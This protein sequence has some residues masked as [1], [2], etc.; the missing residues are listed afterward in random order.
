MATRLTINEAYFLRPL[1]ET[2]D[3]EALFAEVQRSRPYLREWLGWLDGVRD[4]EDSKKF[5]RLS[6]TRGDNRPGM[7]WGIFG[8]RGLLG[9]VDLHHLDAVNRH[10]AIGYWLAYRY[11]GQG[12]MTAAVRRVVR[13][14]FEAMS[15]NRLEIRVNPDNVRSAAIPKRLGFTLEGRLREVEWLYTRFVDHDVYGLLKEKW[16]REQ[17]TQA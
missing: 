8:E 12:I 9:V 16:L 13:Q 3:G 10:A 14:G 11:Q 5:I 17:T 6:Q 2:A 4:V 15:L 7:V 1:E